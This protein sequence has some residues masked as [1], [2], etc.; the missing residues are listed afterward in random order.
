M[1]TIHYRSVEVDGLKVFYREAR[2]VD[3]PKLLPLH[4]FPTAGHM[5]RD[6]IPL[7]AKSVISS[8]GTD[9]ELEGGGPKPTPFFE[10]TTD[11]CGPFRCSRCCLHPSPLD[12]RF[13]RQHLV[14]AGERVQSAAMGGNQ[15]LL[16]RDADV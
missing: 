4:G 6:L 1:T 7:L 9:S 12:C 8:R 2:K 10:L 16:W 3:M 5:L 14:D 15:I 13:P 11:R